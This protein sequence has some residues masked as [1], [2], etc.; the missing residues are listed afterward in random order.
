M[1]NT[2]NRFGWDYAAE[3][4]KFAQEYQLIDI[5]THINGVNA[6]QIYKRVC[7]LY[8]VRMTY[9]MTQN[10]EELGRLEE[11][12]EGRIR[13][14]SIPQ[15]GGDDPLHDHG[16]GYTARIREFHS[17]GSRIAK[18]WSAPRICDL[19]G[20]PYER[21]PL[22]LNAPLRLEG[23]EMAAS[24]GMTFMVFLTIF[25]STTALSPPQ[26]LDNFIKAKL[27]R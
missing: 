9:S 18:F 26:K 12:L 4:L 23:M 27:E 20:G 10:I 8:G 24:L 16:A 3:G 11:V 1:V 7:E 19:V 15:F 14:I 2:S 13:F 5:H 17:R 22:R 25:A 21:Q 6:A